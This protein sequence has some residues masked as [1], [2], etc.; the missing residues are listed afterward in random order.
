MEPATLKV[1]LETQIGLIRDKELRELVRKV[2]D[3]LPEAFWKREAS[4]YYHPIDERGEGGNILHTLRVVKVADKILDTTTYNSLARDIMRVGAILHDCQRHGPDGTAR[5]T[6]KEHPRLAKELVESLIGN[7]TSRRWELL[8]EIIE[9]H[10]GKFQN[11]TYP[12]SEIPLSDILH[13]ADYIASQMDIDV[14]I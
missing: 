8:S 1:L 13:I 10:M 2:V 12:V 9:K 14:R 4:K 6:V 11:P 5:V 3:K 7:G